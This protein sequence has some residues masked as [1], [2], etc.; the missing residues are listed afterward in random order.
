[1]PPTSTVAVAL[2]AAAAVGFLA[3][4]RHE[5]LA[6]KGAAG[7][8]LVVLARRLAPI[9]DPGVALVAHP[10]ASLVAGT[11]VALGRERRASEAR[12]REAAAAP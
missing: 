7:L 6:V 12:A 8:A 5:P 2:G 1:M 11:A 9:V 4:R 10:F 3:R